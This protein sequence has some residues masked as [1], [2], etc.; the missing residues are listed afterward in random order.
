MS[1]YG[2]FW[3][4][5]I[6]GR[7]PHLEKSTRAVMHRLGVDCADVDGLT[8]CPEK[9]MIA[10]MS[11]DTWLLTAARNLSV[12]E[13]AGVD[14][15]TPCPG[16]FGT[17]RG[18]AAE[19]ASSPAQWE[20]VRRGLNHGGRVYRGATRVAHVVELLHRDLGP[21]AI[22]ERVTAPL[23]GMR[24][25]VHYG[26][27]LLKPS[28]ELAVDDP[29]A[30]TKLDELVH[31]LGAASIEYEGKLSCCGGLLS[32]VDDED[33]AQAM[34]RRKLRDATAAGADAICL[35][36]PACFMQYDTTQLVLQ[37]KGEELHV[38]V[39]YYTELLGLALGLA[40]D[41]LG[42]S[43]HRIDV[44]PFVERWKDAR[45]AVARVQEHW[46]YDLLRHC[47]ECG[48]CALDC[49]VAR[50]DPTFDPNRIVRQLAAGQVERT[51]KQGE[52]WRCVECY[53]CREA[54]FQRYSMLDI[55]RIAKHEAVERGLAPAGPTEGMAAFA[56]SGRLVE[57]SASQRKRLGLPEQGA[58]G[59]EELRQMLAAWR[60]ERPR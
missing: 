55:F 31:A 7:L 37:R 11:H 56:K 49:P 52:F 58:T 39:L 8:C 60:P 26:C 15:L 53:T 19:I 18:A 6:Q 14:L 35:A 1:R 21:S 29:S 17:L 27:H 23:T 33:T 59:A 44:A 48:A 28:G 4:C 25:A 32:R 24:V 5:Y 41:D 47:A 30:P 36:C 22:R 45:E 10:N 2:Y 40:A 34:A 12:A 16:C 42:L 9:S 51:L 54:C 46:Q 57:G 13:A 3:G 20:Q 38:P 50:A 43:A